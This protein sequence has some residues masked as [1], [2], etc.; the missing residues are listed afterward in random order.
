MMVV[1]AESRQAILSFFNYRNW[2]PEYTPEIESHI[3]DLLRY[4]P[5]GHS[6]F[7]QL[8]AYFDHQKIIIPSYRTL[9]EMFG[10]AF[11][12]E[13]KRMNAIMTNIPASEKEQLSS[14]IYRDDG[15]TALNII[16]ADQKDFQYTAVKTE[17]D[18]ALRIVDL[19]AF[20]KGFIPGCNPSSAPSQAIIG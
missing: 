1:G 15:I 16:R 9:Q 10:R 14:L 12:A 2:S 11:N 4:Y 13:E 7:R 18:K 19:Y 6:A 5:K 3:S 20:A 8:L 17:V